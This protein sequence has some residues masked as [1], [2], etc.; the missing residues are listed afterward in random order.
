MAFT[1]PGRAP[2]PRGLDGLVFLEGEAEIGLLTFLL[3]R[4]SVTHLT[5]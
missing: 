2:P 1:A 5:D 3:E 4:S